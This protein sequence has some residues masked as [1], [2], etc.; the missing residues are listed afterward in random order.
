MS[1]PFDPKQVPPTGTVDT[2]ARAERG[3]RPFG[4]PPGAIQF[5]T[6][7]PRLGGDVASDPR[8]APSA[9]H[10]QPLDDGALGITNSPRLP[11]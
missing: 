4:P 3:N 6:Q 10:S 11:R 9:A 5:T 7:R 1:K 8:A 2:Q